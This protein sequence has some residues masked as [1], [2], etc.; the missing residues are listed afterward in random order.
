MNVNLCD[1]LGNEIKD[2]IKLVKTETIK[3]TTIS[4][5]KMNEYNFSN[6]GQRINAYTLI[7]GMEE[8]ILIEFTS[9]EVGNRVIMIKDRFFSEISKETIELLKTRNDKMELNENK[10]DESEL[11]EMLKYVPEEIV[12]IEQVLSVL[13]VEPDFTL[14]NNIFKEY[15]ES[16][17]RIRNSQTEYIKTFNKNCNIKRSL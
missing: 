10:S 8:C 3:S 9:F 13:S 7:P 11:L 6:N 15:C 4:S 12:L 16:V 2:L 17:K 1:I 5:F 14:L